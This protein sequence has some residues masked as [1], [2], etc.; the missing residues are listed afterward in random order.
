LAENLH[1][2]QERIAAACQRA[3]RSPDDVRLVAITKTVDLEVIKQLIELGQHDIGESRTHELIS[4]ATG[5]QEQAEDQPSQGKPIRWHLVGHLQRN[6]VRPVIPWASLIH[7]LDSLRLAEEISAHAQRQQNTVDV[8]LQVNA[9]GERS[10]FGVA[11]GAVTYLIEQIATL[12]G[13]RLRGLMT[14]APLASDPEEVRPVFV[15]LRELHEELG[16]SRLAGPDFNDLSMGMSND[17]EVAVEEGATM[18]RVGTAL[19][20]GLPG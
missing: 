3:G 19:F 5:F 16:A 1:Q 9:S 10:K 20:E 4:R 2:V 7:S 13:L 6:K 11:V 8:L 14:M 12:P 17:F 18:V 15:R